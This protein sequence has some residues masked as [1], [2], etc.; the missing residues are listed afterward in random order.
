MC[1]EIFT[2]CLHT[3]LWRSDYLD[4]AVLFC[5]HM[6]MGFVF[7]NCVQTLLP[8]GMSYDAIGEKWHTLI[9]FCGSIE[10]L[11]GPRISVG[12]VVPVW[13]FWKRD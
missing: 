7:M 13:V 8:G 2:I 10:E 12:R 1:V 11:T 9:E 5:I 3:C 4:T 6:F